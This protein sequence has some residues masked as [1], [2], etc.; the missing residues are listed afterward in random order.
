MNKDLEAFSRAI[1]A[2]YEASA[3]GDQWPQALDA[4]MRLLQASKGGIFDIA[5]ER[6]VHLTALGHDPA[7]QAEY[8]AHYMAIDPTWQT[9]M[10]TPPHEVRTSYEAFPVAVRKHSEYFNFARSVDIGDVIAVKTHGA[11]GNCTMVSLQRAYDAPHFDATTKQLM[12]LLVSHIE[13]AKRV[14]LRLTEAEAARQVFSAGLDRFASAAFI[15]DST[16][17]IC[18]LNAAARSLLAGEH[19]VR[20]IHGK[21][22]FKEPGLN[23]KFEGALRS[24]VRE[25]GRAAVLACQLTLQMA[26]VVVSPLRPAQDLISAWQVPLALVIIAVP[27]RD[28]QWIATRMQQLHGLTPAEAQVVAHLALGETVES[29]TLRN[30]VSESTIRSQLK[31]IFSKAA[32][33][34]Q[35]DL[36]RLAL[37]GVPLITDEA[38]P[39]SPRKG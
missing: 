17:L 27:R 11:A 31:S 38:E 25:N 22:G 30:G 13:I 36:V 29:I 6:P 20:T 26:E 3:A 10:E 18:H 15:V 32:V 23:A 34:R 1:A 8:L 21:L 37:A 33:S 4:V 14:Q 2:I 28:A 7:V 12:Q 35:A 5:E 24:A 19:R 39:Y 9:G 16:A